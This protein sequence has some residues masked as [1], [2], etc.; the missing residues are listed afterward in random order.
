[1]CVPYLQKVLVIY[2]RILR[3]GPQ[4]TKHGFQQGDVLAAEQLHLL[5]EGFAHRDAHGQP[6]LRPPSQVGL[7]PAHFRITPRLIRT[8]AGSPV[9]RRS[10]S[11]TLAATSRSAS[12]S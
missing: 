5:L 2:V 10:H 8:V 3:A 4:P 11:A 9:L 7:P 6:E 12:S 1:M